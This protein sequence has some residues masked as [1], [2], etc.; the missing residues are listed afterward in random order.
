MLAGKISWEKHICTFEI[1]LGKNI[2]LLYCP[3]PLLEEKS[4]SKNPILE[5]C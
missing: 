5:L 2:G 1:K 4:L 3:K